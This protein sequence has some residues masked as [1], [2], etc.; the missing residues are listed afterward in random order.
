MKKGI[1]IFVTVTLFSSLVTMGVKIQDNK[2]GLYS[3]TGGELAKDMGKALNKLNI[4]YVKID[5]TDINKGNLSS[6]STIIFPGGKTEALYSTLK[7]QGFSKIRNFVEK[8]G[9]YIGI[10]A[11]AYIA[12]PEVEIKGTPEGLG[13]INI[14]NNRERE[15]GL[16]KITLK[17]HFITKNYQEEVSIYYQNGPIIVPKDDNVEE[18]AT[19]KE[20]QAAAIVE[21]SYGKGKV[22]IFSP[23]P[24]GSSKF[25]VNPRKL[26][27]LK[28][29]KSSII[30]CQK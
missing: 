3:D 19:Y 18:I 22:I 21:S 4:P 8:G 30:Y 2:I 15:Y 6:F 25:N 27:T 29:L 13:I 11:G 24:E 12:A 9:N 10:C 1:L 5:S 26:G 7:G 28:L 17:D 14:E 20:Q 16:R 23:H